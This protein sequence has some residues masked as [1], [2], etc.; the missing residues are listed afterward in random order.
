[1]II[2][3]REWVFE[4]KLRVLVLDRDTAGRYT[5]VYTPLRHRQG[6]AM[7][8]ILFGKFW[9]FLAQLQEVGPV[10]NLHFVL[11]Y[12][13]KLERLQL[14]RMELP[15]YLNIYADLDNTADAISVTFEKLTPA[16]EL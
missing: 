14:Q 12:H 15:E 4:V 1:V 2:P 9:I 16:N 11:V 8:H 10:G 5:R 6:R 7:P 3:E 13:K